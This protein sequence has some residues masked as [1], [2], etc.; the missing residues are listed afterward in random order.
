M[1][2]SSA[3]VMLVAGMQDAMGV[4][5]FATSDGAFAAEALFDAYRSGDAEEVRKCVQTHSTF[6]E[7]DNQ[8]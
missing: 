7:L 1:W 5:T 2:A 8:V 3:K 4:D 6:M